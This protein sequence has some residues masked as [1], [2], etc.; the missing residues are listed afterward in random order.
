MNWTTNWTK[1]I[2]HAGLISYNATRVMGSKAESGLPKHRS[3]MTVAFASCRRL[4]ISILVSFILGGAIA[5]EAD[6]AS[7]R[8]KLLKSA[9]ALRRESAKHPQRF[10]D[11][12]VYNVRST[13]IAGACFRQ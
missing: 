11:V 8:E 13:T 6:A 9:D 3:L 4:L 10:R 2:D 1:I 12:G 7:A 5:G